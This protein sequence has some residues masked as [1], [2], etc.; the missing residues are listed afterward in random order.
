M[1]KILL[2][3]FILFQVVIAGDR[4][5]TGFE[6]LR[7]DFNPRTA[8]MAG[9]FLT[10][11]GDVN[12]VFINPAGTADLQQQN[13]SFNYTGYLLDINGGT[14]AYNRVFPKLGVL[15]AGVAY[16]DFGAFDATDNDAVST[17]STFSAN[18]FAFITGWSGHLDE[19]FSYGINAKYIFSK[20]ERYSAS[21]LALDFGM[22]Y[23]APFEQNL[24]FAVTLSNVGTNITY[25]KNQKE[26]LPQSLRIGVSKKLAHLPLEITLSLNDLNRSGESVA[27]YFKRFSVG[28]EFRASEMLRLRAGYDYSLY[29]GLNSTENEKF[30]GISA[31]VGILWKTFRLDYSYSNFSVLGNVH[32]FGFSG[33]IP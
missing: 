30:G 10:M 8:A 16:M 9:S 23:K 28:G 18:S 29:D 4:L 13:Y 24:V 11:T 5:T 6:F 33:S 1:R 12:G 25:F 15:T 3:L 21:A 32:R 20:I 19:H 31:G 7:T 26:P 22:L 2:A 17:G 14:A 27:D